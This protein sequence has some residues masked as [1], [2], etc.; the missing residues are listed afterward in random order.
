MVTDKNARPQE[1][2][3]AVHCFCEC[4]GSALLGD[5]FLGVSRSVKCDFLSVLSYTTFLPRD[6]MRKRGL[7][8][9]PSVCLSNCLSVTFMDCIQTAEVIITPLSRP[10]SSIILVFDRLPRYPIPRETPSAGALNTPAV[11]KMRFS[12]EIVIYLQNGTR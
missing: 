10:G 2:L 11:G 1:D 9:R 8:C 3:L 12:P 5:R 4:S 6:A 7:C